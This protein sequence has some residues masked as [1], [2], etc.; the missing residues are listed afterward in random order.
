MTN[1][2]EKT[3]G[4]NFFK[5]GFTKSHKRLIGIY[6]KMRQR[7][8]NKKDKG[9]VDYGGRGISISNEWDEYINF[10][11]WAILSG[12][13]EN[14]TIDRIDNDGN[15]EP[16]NCRWV[17]MKTQCRNRRSSS[18][19]LID[20]EYKTYAELSEIYGIGA[21]LISQRINRDNRTIKQALGIEPY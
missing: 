19:V 16:D 15:Y 6:S 18:R 17:D 14:L 13:K 12:Y 1:I 10:H 11:N 7:C 21:R 3:T 2:T 8:L 5:H 4:L 9:Y 20:G